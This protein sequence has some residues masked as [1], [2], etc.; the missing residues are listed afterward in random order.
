[1]PTGPFLLGKYSTAG[2]VLSD[3]MVELGASAPV[4]DPI[5]LAAAGDPLWTQVMTLTTAAA[6]DLL[7]RREWQT[8]IRFYTFTTTGGSGPLPQA[9]SF[10]VDYDRMVDQTSWNTSQRMPVAGPLTQQYTQFLSAWTG[11]Q[12]YI[13]LGFLNQGDDYNIFPATASSGQVITYKYISRNWCQPATTTDPAVRTESIAAAG[14]AILFEPFLFSRALKL[15]W[16]TE[17]R[18]DTTAAQDDFDN[19]YEQQAGADAG[20]QTLNL[21]TPNTGIPFIDPRYNLPPTGYG[22]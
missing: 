14:D 6:R 2:V 11:G 22:T 17:K 21:A 13:Y 18:F 9:Y 8:F 20:A 1:M 10:P 4:A 5:A 7:R 19:A 16:L 3:T 15:R 12:F